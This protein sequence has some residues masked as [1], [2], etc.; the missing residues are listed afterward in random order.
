MN[1]AGDI[2]KRKKLL[3]SI[4]LFQNF[5]EDILNS[6]AKS[7]EYCVFIRGDIVIEQGKQG[8]KLFI[9]ERG[10]IDVFFMKP[11]YDPSQHAPTEPGLPVV[12]R[13]LM[14][15]SSGK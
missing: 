1:A 7:L 4:T 6:I 8:E 9:I 14:R 3:K 12:G 11:G 15:L 2:T 13:K 5:S 10:S